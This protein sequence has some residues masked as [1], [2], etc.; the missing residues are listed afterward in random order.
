PTSGSLGYAHHATFRPALRSVRGR[1]SAPLRGKSLLRRARDAARAA[2][3]G[4]RAHARVPFFSFRQDRVRPDVPYA[5]SVSPAA[6]V[7]GPID[8][9]LL[10]LGRLAGIGILQQE[11]ATR[12]ALLAASVHPASLGPASCGG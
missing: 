2:R 8:T 10:D 3:C 6:G 12:T 9:L 11:G 1:G 5:D 4:A 7:H